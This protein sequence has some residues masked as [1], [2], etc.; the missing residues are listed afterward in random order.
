MIIIPRHPLLILSSEFSELCKPLEIINVSHIT[1]QK[2]Y[3]DGSRIALSNKTQ[4]IEDYYNLNLYQSSLFEGEPVQY[5]SEFNVWLGEYD[6]P[7]YLHGKT[8]YN[9]AHSITITE[10]VHD[11]CEFYIFAVSAE[12]TRIIHYLV[13]NIDILYHFIMYFK[14]RGAKLLKTAHRHRLILSKSHRSQ[15]EP[16][17]LLSDKDYQQELH[18]LKKQFYQGTSIHKYSFEK[19]DINGVKLTQREIQCLFYLLHKKTASETAKLMNISRRTVESYL[20]SI[21][22]K[23]NCDFKADIFTKLKDN[24]Y[25]LAARLGI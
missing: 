15:N 21:K 14:D 8:Y 3:K 4:W 7:V 1:Y 13:N 16:I 24:Q 22:R 11:G 10:P 17:T 12:H 19:G 2:Q 23:I 5:Q 20:D 6:L 9:S 18:N 25:L